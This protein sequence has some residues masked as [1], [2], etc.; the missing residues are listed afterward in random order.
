MNTDTIYSLFQQKMLEAP[1]KAAVFDSRRLLTMQELDAMAD[2]IAACLPENETRI[3]I[4]MDHSAEMIAA[5]FAVLKRG[6]AYV[7]AEPSFPDERIRFMMQ[8]AGV[9]TIITGSAYKERFRDFTAVIVDRGFPLPERR[10]AQPCRAHADDLAYI[11]YTSGST[12]MPKGVAVRNRNVCHYVRA[13]INEFHPDESDTMLQYSV[14]SFD[15]FVEEV[16]TTLLSGAVLAIPSE[17]DKKDIGSLM[18][19][20]SRHHVT[21]ISGFPYLLQDMNRLPAIPSCLRLLISGG[22]VLRGVYVDR[23]LSQAEVYNTYGPSET[24]VCAAYYRC[25]GQQP[26]EDGTYPVGRPVL[27]AQIAIM[28]ENLRPVPDGQTGEICIS[29]GGVCAGYIGR[30][31]AENDAFVHMEDGRVL[32]RSGDL[33]RILPDG[34]IAFLRRRDTQVMI[35]GRRVE[36]AEVETALYKCGGI[37]KAAVKAYQDEQHLSYLVA[38]IVTKGDGITL[39]GI[40]RTLRRFLPSYMIPE[41]FVQMPDL[42]LNANG[43][44]DAQALPVVM[45]EGSR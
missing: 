14:C 40:R 23:L 32:Y 34:N 8:D 26:L 18:D 44:V 43:K 5:I 12:G 24:T 17:E 9:R 3:G 39:S 33:G 30:S 13:F 27:G 42:P 36:P 25:T 38:Y 2:A 29:G 10:E 15:I 28:D 41:F 19:F 6:G 35:L 11:L 21:E 7:P 31:R 37:E 20:V 16:F 1:S 45:K 4:V 22:D